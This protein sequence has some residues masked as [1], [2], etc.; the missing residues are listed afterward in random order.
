MR[1]ISI[2]VTGELGVVKCAIDDMQKLSRG[3]I[4]LGWTPITDYPTCALL[5]KFNS[6]CPGPP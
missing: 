1:T 3:P 4:R 5:V 2:C 6:L